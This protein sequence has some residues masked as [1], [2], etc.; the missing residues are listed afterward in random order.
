MSTTVTAWAARGP[1]FDACSVNVTDPPGPVFAEAW[2]A[3][4][5]PGGTGVGVAGRV[6]VRVGV[7]VCLV[8]AVRLRFGGEGCRALDVRGAVGVGVHVGVRV[9]VGVAVLVPV[10]VG[11]RVAVGIEVRVGVGVA[12]RRAVGVPVR[13]GVHVGVG[14]DVGVRVGVD[15]TTWNDAV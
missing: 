9:A 5:A 14:G 10:V 7:R 2:I 8:V 1:A 11:V 4:S 3:T 15:A 13:V 6:D 12:V